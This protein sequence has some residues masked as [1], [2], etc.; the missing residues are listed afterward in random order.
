MCSQKF[1]NLKPKTPMLERK[2]NSSIEAGM[3]EAIAN[4]SPRECMGEALVH[5]ERRADFINTSNSNCRTDER[6]DER[7]RGKV[8]VQATT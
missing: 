2:D 8:P 7:I 1:M 3:M 4:R 5:K 6:S